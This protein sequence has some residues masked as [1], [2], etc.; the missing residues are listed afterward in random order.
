MNVCILY[1]PYSTEEFNEGTTPDRIFKFLLKESL[2]KHV[3][4]CEE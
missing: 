4:V 3:H 1:T 2:L